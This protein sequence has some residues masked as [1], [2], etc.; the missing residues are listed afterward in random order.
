MRVSG[1]HVRLLDEGG[2]VVRLVRARDE[3]IAGAAGP[4]ALIG[5]LAV[6]ARASGAYR[7]TND[8]DAVAEPEALGVVLTERGKRLGPRGPWPESKST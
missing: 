5:G 4:A 6:L 2:A 8:V 3:V 7:V 1:E